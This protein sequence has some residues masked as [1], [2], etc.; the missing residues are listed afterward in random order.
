MQNSGFFGARTKLATGSGEVE[1]YSLKTLDEKV[2]GDIF[3]LPFSIRVMLE[4]L[5]RNAGG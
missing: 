5:L 2:G 1:I 4:S 3:S